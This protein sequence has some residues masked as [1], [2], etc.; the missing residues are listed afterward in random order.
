MFEALKKKLNKDKHLSELTKGSITAL[1]LKIISLSIGYIS[2]LYIT[3]VYG[4][5]EF[6]SFTLSLTMVSIFALIPKLGMDNA[7][8]RIIGELN[9]HKYFS[10][11]MSVSK[12]VLI[13]TGTLSLL[14]VLFFYQLTDS[15]VEKFNQGEYLGE[16]MKIASVAIF[17]TTIITIISAIFQGLKRTKEFIFV[18]TILNQ[19]IL[20]IFLFVNSE[21]RVV[22]YV[23]TVYVYSNIVSAIISMFLL[24]RL[25]K[26][27]SSTATVKSYKYNYR[28]I[29]EISAPMLFTGAL[30]MLMG[31]TD[32]IM[33]GIYTNEANV[34]VYSAA[35]RLAGITSLSLVAINV[36][37]APK[38][39]EFYVK[40]NLKGLEKII[41]Q[42]TKLIFL[43][44][45]PIL[46]IFITFPR[47]ILSLFGDE[48]VIGWAVL[49]LISIGSFV[50]SFSG[51]VGYI[52]QMTDNQKIFRNVIIVATIINIILNFILIPN[53]GINGAAFAT[54]TSTIFW[55]VV[56]VIIIKNRLGFWTLY[57][58]FLKAL[59]SGGSVKK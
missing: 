13:A 30:G 44:S 6:G 42:S 16:Y 14:F 8:V 45:F 17:T 23:I 47:S 9:T 53:Y 55:N 11:L 43:T 51:S 3:N 12:R 36:I 56:L 19:F 46:L 15:I 25:F 39:V 26:S 27:L 35:Q 57:I 37:A 29:F 21:L 38:F 18:Q 32:I 7:L 22:D 41:R 58:P 52:M 28:R 34:G 50:N 1:L 10:E 48:F 2:M 20:I 5:K 49:I 4:A 59:A 33:L 54:M 40:K 24:S 31:W